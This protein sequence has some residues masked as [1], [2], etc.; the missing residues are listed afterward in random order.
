MNTL[1]CHIIHRLL[2]SVGLLVVALIVFFV[3]LHYLEHVDDFMDRG[4]TWKQVFL[5]DEERGTLGYYPSLVPEIVRLVS[6]L[7][8]FL[9]CVY[10]TGKLAQELQIV[11]L[12][13]AGVSLWRVLRPYLLV[14]VGI[15]GFMFWFNGWI[16]P[17]TNA[18]VIAFEQE[19]LKDAARPSS[20]TDIHLQERPG[21]FITVGFYDQH[22]QTA[23]RVSLQDFDAGERLLHR[24]DAQRMVWSDSLR[25]WSLREATVRTFSPEGE[26]RTQVAAIDTLLNVRPYDLARTER[27][28]EAMTIP[29]AARYLETLQATGISMTGRSFVAYYS[30]Y[31]YPLANLILV[32]ISVPLAVRRR[33]GGQAVR[34]GIGLFVA[35]LYLAAQ[36]LSEPFGYDGQLPP[37]VA[38]WLPH[39]VFFA[40]ALLLLAS[41]RR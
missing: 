24:I 32:L 41:A 16:V 1:D 18:T 15:T 10:L 28:V 4:A 39:G 35:F 7:A 31:S 25:R 40:L 9:A 26:R 30:K 23:H 38:A 27:D 12:Q 3:V 34:I 5:V 14:G 13:S 2:Q 37:L 20:V 33:R 22:T 6:P 19:Y 36:K 17:H 11:A 21:R 8:V 29:A